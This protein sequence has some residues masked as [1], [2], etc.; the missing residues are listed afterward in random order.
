MNADYQCCDC[1]YQWQSSPG[2][3]NGC[4]K[5]GCLYNVWLN[6]AQFKKEI[7]QQKQ[8]V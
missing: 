3:T 8:K 1:Q 6:F 7:S 2:P 5:C 4:P